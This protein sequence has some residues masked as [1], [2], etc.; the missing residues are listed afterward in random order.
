VSTT[1]LAVDDSVTMRKVLEITFAG[2]DYRI[3][4]ADGADAA[5]KKAQAEKPNIVVL[6]VTL[7]GQDGY[8]TCR[9]LKAQNPAVSVVLLSSKQFPYDAAKGSAAGA[10]DYID[11]P[12]DTQAMIEKVRKVIQARASAPAQPAA[13]AP[14]PAAKPAEVTA[15]RSVTGTLPGG[16]QASPTPAAKP[17]GQPVG[18]G[19]QVFPSGSPGPEKAAAQPVAAK[20]APTPAA[21]QPKPATTTMLGPTG[22]LASAASTA[23]TSTSQQAVTPPTPAA[24][25]QP[26]PAAAPT[27][28]RP[29]AAAAPVAAPPAPQPTPAPSPVAAAV[30]GQMGA[31]LAGLGLSP[32]QAEAVLALSREVIER[33]VWEV[34]PQLAETLIKEELQR[35]TAEG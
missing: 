22:G 17:A 20:P 12:F 29:A 24:K 16:G 35:L 15:A 10:D 28:A 2:E 33:V 1:L 23:T 19:T 31:K 30:D 18:R 8:A 26:T 9:A 4:T 27:P 11:K 21:P 3:V 25:P 34:V 6:D 32:Q 14:T 13:P 5:V 7:T